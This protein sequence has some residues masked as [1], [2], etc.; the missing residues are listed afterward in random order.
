MFHTSQNEWL[1]L[2][3]PTRVLSTITAAGPTYETLNNDKKKTN[4]KQFFFKDNKI[5]LSITTM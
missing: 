4:A 1:K 5:E 2:L 3:Y